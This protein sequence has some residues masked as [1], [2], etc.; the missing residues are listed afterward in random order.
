MKVDNFEK[1]I[2]T[3]CK[4]CVETKNQNYCS[5]DNNER[6]FIGTWTTDEVNKAISKGYKIFDKT[7][8]DLFKCYIQK[9]MKIKLESSNYDFK[10]KDE[11]DIFKSKTKK[12][13]DIDIDRFKYNAGLRN[14]SKLCLNSVWG[15]FGQ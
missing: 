6:S 2:F 12:S 4:K 10:T 15:K 13:L 7:R 1:L 3:L 8:D 9:F 11:E 5:H 14:I